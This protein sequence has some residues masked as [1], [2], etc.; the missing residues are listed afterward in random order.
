M[1][2]CWVILLA[3]TATAGTMHSHAHPAAITDGAP[4]NP[5]ASHAVSPFGVKPEAKRLHC[6]L[7]GHNPLLPCPHHKIPAEGK[8]NFYLSNGCGGGPFQAPFYRSFG[9]SPRFL[10]P[11]ATVEED[12]PVALHVFSSTVFYD[13]TFTFSL[14]RP[15]RAL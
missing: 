15:P 7:L 12:V 5:Q 14:D 3:S 9:D 11:V 6:E 2:C 10:I 4:W 1:A 8:D 13:S